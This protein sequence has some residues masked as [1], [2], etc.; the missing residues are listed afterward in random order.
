MAQAREIGEAKMADLNANF[1]ADA[2]AKI[3]AGNPSWASPSRT[4][5]NQPCPREPGHARHPTLRRRRSR[6]TKR[7][8]AAARRQGSP[9]G[10]A[11]PPS[12]A[13]KPNPGTTVWVQFDR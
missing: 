9:R 8:R 4:D 1:D 2:T 7:S 12:E 13:M 11:A 5:T 10:R 6:M 3:I